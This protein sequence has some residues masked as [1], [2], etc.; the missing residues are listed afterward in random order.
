MNAQ[1]STRN[2]KTRLG[3]LRWLLIVLFLFFVWV[4]GKA[5]LY[6]VR[7]LSG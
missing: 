2:K 1:K 4:I 7:I 5:V 3:S 6:L